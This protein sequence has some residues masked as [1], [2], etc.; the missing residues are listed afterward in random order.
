MS[1]KKGIPRE[2]L[3][4]FPEKIDDYIDQN[5]QIRFVDAF[6]NNLDLQELGFKYSIPKMGSGRNP[7]DP[8]DMLKLYIYGYLNNIRSSRKLEVETHRNIEIMWLIGKLKPD[9]KTI[10]N[11][12]RDNTNCFKKT[13]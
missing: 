6:V 4:L 10:S 11:F 3:T 7:Y 5:N 12:R 1:Y 9:H 2:Q 8:Y 13:L